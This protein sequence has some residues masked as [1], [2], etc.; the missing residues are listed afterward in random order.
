MGAFAVFWAAVNQRAWSDKIV[1]LAAA[2]PAAVLVNSARIVLIGFGYLLFEGGS[3][4]HLIHDLSGIAMIFASFGVMWL[5]SVYWQH[6]WAP[7]KK[8]TARELLQDSG[9]K[10]GRG[11]EVVVDSPLGDG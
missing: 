9:A 3:V 2:I 10:Y 1:I 8:L 5:V 6:L 7:V 11:A 4:R